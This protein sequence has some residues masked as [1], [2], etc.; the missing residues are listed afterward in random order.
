MTFKFYTIKLGEQKNMLNKAYNEPLQS[1]Q[2]FPSYLYMLEQKI[3]DTITKIKTDSKNM[4]EYLFMALGL[5]INDF[6]SRCRLF[7]AIDGTHLKRTFKGVIC[8]VAAKNGNEQ[9]YPIVFGFGDGR[10][11]VHG[12]DF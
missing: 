5:S 12:L 6:R 3:P 10:L 9:I 4:F 1:F 8:V 11:I 7:I 2:K